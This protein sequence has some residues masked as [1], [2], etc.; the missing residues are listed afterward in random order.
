MS[1]LCIINFF[2]NYLENYILYSIK[3]KSRLLNRINLH[4]YLYIEQSYNYRH[5]QF[6]TNC[7]LIFSTK[8][9]SDLPHPSVIVPPS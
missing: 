8:T 4:K 9:A 7:D 2:Y 6:L 3:V 1:I 5:V